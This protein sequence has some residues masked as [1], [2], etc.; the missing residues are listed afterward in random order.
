M[1]NAPHPHSTNGVLPLQDA[2]LPSEDFSKGVVFYLSENSRRV[3]G[4]LTW[5]IFGKMDLAREVCT[6]LVKSVVIRAVTS[7]VLSVCLF[8]SLQKRRQKQTLASWLPS[9]KF[10]RG[11][12]PLCGQC[13]TTSCT[14]LSY[15]YCL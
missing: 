3:V 2:A 10:S 6:D 5:N 11:G 15:S 4:V 14:I 12:G 13:I 7:P 9:L 8:R 1:P